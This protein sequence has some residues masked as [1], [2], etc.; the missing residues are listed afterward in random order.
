MLVLGLCAEHH[1]HDDTDPLG[2]IGVHPYKA[3]F[4][5]RYGT[6]L[7]LLAEAKQKLGLA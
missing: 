1:Q 2:R 6:Q 3:R 5:A 4:E 7:Q